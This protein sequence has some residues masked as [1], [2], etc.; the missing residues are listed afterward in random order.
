MTKSSQDSLDITTPTRNAKINRIRKMDDER[1][2]NKMNL[3][4]T[5][6]LRKG[7]SQISDLNSDEPRPN[8]KREFTDFT[9]SDNKRPKID[10]EKYQRMVSLD[11][12]NTIK[13]NRRAEP[14]GKFTLGYTP[15]KFLE[16]MEAQ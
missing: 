9:E 6:Q 7:E 14:I 12:L 16:H 10:K 11:Q 1:V 2:Q 3:M 8:L 5:L 13:L 15:E 4:S